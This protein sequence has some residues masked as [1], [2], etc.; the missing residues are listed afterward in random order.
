MLLLFL[1]RVTSPGAEFYRR[2]YIPQRLVQ[3]LS[4]PVLPRDSDDLT[5]AFPLLLQ[6]RE[7]LLDIYT[8]SNP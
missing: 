4:H 5:E 8:L 7:S 1:V 6:S 3:E 2:V